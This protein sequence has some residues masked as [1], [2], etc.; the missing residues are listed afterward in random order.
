MFISKVQ[1]FFYDELLFLHDPRKAAAYVIQSR[2]FITIH[3]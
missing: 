2:S 1:K 3:F